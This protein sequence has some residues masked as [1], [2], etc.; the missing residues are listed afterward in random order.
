MIDA[1]VVGPDAWNAGRYSAAL[2][3]IWSPILFTENYQCRRPSKDKGGDLVQWGEMNG[4]GL[5]PF[6]VGNVATQVLT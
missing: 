6:V 2:F 3:K 4:L 1:E 5:F